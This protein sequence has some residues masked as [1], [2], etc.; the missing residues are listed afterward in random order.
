M[1]PMSLAK[2]PYEAPYECLLKAC[3]VCD[4]GI[5]LDKHH[6]IFRNGDITH[7]VHTALVLSHYYLLKKMNDIYLCLCYPF[8]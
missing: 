7:I 4:R 5:N 2:A 3:S 8:M 1:G 6:G